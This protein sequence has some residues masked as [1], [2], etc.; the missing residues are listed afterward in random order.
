L[1]NSKLF[2]DIKDI[3]I[4]ASAYFGI[5]GTLTLS[6]QLSCHSIIKITRVGRPESDIQDLIIKLD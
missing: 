1:K 2:R 4:N 5:F 6:V 3:K